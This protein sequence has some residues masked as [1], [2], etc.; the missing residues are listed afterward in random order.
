MVGVSVAYHLLDGQAG[1]AERPRA[2]L[3]EVKEMCSG[4]GAE[5]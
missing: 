3:L 5:W 2:V 1:D 4:D